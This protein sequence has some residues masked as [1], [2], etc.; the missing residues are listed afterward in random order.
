MNALLPLTDLKTVF[1]FQKFNQYPLKMIISKINYET[2]LVLGW[3]ELPKGYI[4]SETDMYDL[5]Y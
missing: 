4:F 1:K 3:D 2:Y 5:I